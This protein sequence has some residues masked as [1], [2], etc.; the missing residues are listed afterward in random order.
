MTAFGAPDPAMPRRSALPDAELQR[1][2]RQTLLPGIGLAGQERLHQAHVAV[3]GAGG[4]GCPLMQQLAAAGVGTITVLDDDVISLSNLQRQILFGASDIGRPKV[5]VVAERLTEIQPGITINA[6]RVRFDSDTAAA[7][8]ADA[9]ILVDGSDTFATKFFAA[10]AA[11]ATATPLVWGSV[12]RY[13]GDVAVWWSGQNRRGVGMRDL[14]PQE[15][16]ADSV[17]DCATAGVLGVTTS[18]V[19]GLM[20]TEVIKLLCHLVPDLDLEPTAAASEYQSVGQLLIY[21]AVT[22]SVTRFSVPA[23]PARLLET[24]IPEGVRHQVAAD[25]PL[26]DEETEE[27]LDAVR[28]SEG[29]AIDVRE[30]TE[31]ALSDIPGGA[32]AYHLPTSVWSGDRASA[33]SLLEHLST[34]QEPE[35]GQRVAPVLV[36]CASGKRSAAFIEEFQ[37][38]AANVGLTLVNLPGGTQQHASA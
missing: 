4:L 1:V 8:L 3:I 30:E 18:V 28:D 24:E 31:K 10:D 16:A 13:R 17:P 15:P 20:A 11:E 2:A 6:H 7:V 27:L 32:A 9:D 34:G 35:D 21:D 14:Y 37:S 5:E 12:L 33:L 38:D 29:L 26:V 25:A 19:A 23:D 36:Y 22:A